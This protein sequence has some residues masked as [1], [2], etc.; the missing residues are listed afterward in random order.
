M[1]VAPHNQ[2]AESADYT[3]AGA[4]FSCRNEW[5]MKKTTAMQMQESATLNAGHG[6]ANGTCRSNRRKSITWPYSSRSV[7][8]PSTPASNKASERSRQTLGV[9]QTDLVSP[10]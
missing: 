2:R 10:D 1:T 4:F 5:I 3:A 6:W 7:R 8:L 9:H